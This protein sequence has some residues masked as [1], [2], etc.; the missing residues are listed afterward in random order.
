MLILIIIKARVVILITHKVDFRE[1]I[2]ISGTLY[3]ALVKSIK[4]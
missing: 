4:T 2:R 3:N 1:K